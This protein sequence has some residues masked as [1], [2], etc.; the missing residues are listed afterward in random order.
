MQA[1]TPKQ[2][3]PLSYKDLQQTAGA[4]DIIGP[5]IPLL[6]GFC[7]VI[8]DIRIRDSVEF[9]PY[10][11]PSLYWYRLD[12]MQTL[13]EIPIFSKIAGPGSPGSPGVPGHPWTPEMVKMKNFG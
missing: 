2:R 8:T 10:L 6:L 13:A 3:K 12:G 7:Q 11:L 1:R 4:G 9:L 5:P